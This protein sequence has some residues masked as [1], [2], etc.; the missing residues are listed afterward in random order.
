M[1][2]VGDE[3]SAS[4]RRMRDSQRYWV[5]PDEPAVSLS[6]GGCRLR[7]WHTGTT[8]T[9]FY[10]SGS[11]KRLVGLTEENVSGGDGLELAI[12]EPKLYAATVVD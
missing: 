4:L 10:R 9:T 1:V 3:V 12:I 5:V 7:A 8:S 2:S 11:R 6:Y